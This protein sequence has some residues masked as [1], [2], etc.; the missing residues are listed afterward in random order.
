MLLDHMDIF[1]I[2]AW[3]SAS[4]LVASAVFVLTC[5]KDGRYSE[6]AS[7]IPYCLAA[8]LVFGLVNPFGDTYRRNRRFFLQILNRVV[9]PFR[10]VTFSDFLLADILTSLAKPLSDLSIASC[11]ML[12]FDV[13]PQGLERDARD[14]E[15]D[16]PG[17]SGMCRL[18]S[19]F[20]HFILALPFI[21]RLLQCVRVYRSTREVPNLANALKYFSALP[22][23]YLYSFRYTMPPHM[24]DESLRGKWLA[25]ALLNSCFCYYWDLTWDWE[26]GVCSMS[27]WRGGGLLRTE[28]VYSGIGIWALSGAYTWAVL[29]NLVL[30]FVWLHKVSST[31]LDLPFISLVACLL[32]VFRRFQWTY[33]RIEVALLKESRAASNSH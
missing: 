6:R 9:L 15:G 13:A 28:N 21:W 16:I 30:R 23:I 17:G 20:P 11:R 29:S 14:I 25:F 19:W 7:S 32:E 27:V 31:M 12:S 8:L 1:G 24:W 4:C 2:A 26:F 10:E 22:V 33:I 5:L 18:D 3:I